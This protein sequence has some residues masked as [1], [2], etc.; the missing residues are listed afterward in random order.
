M[1]FVA[2]EHNLPTIILCVWR[3]AAPQTQTQE[4]LPFGYSWTRQIRYD[5]EDEKRKVFRKVLQV[6]MSFEMEAK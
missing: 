6:E 1:R 5:V 3:I 2:Q 4:R